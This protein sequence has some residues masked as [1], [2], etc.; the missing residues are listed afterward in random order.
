MKKI[1]LLIVFGCLFIG[2]VMFQLLKQGVSLQ[3]RKM[4][5]WSTVPSAEEVGTI[6]ALHI[7]PMLKEKGEFVVYGNS[8]KAEKF[9]KSFQAQALNEGIKAKL[10]FNTQFEKFDG[11]TLHWMELKDGGDEKSCQKGVRLECLKGRAFRE[12]QKKSR[13]TNKM[14][15][16]MWR[17]SEKE[18]VLF[19]VE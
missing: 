3:E 13:D 5:K 12:F 14:W 19:F 6:V 7:Y 18:I 16:Q 11:Y 9:F 10:Y 15:I 8:D 4:I 1:I 17:I 2:F